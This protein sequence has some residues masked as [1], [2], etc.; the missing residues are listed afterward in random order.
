MISEVV[1]HIGMHK[2]GTTA[3]QSCLKN[4]DDGSIRMARLPDINHSVPIYSLFSESRNDYFVH[5]KKGLNANQIKEYNQKSKIRLKNEL[6]L[7]RDKLIIS[8]ED[9]SLLTK[10]EV[11]A[12]ISFLKERASKVRVIAYVRDPV[13]FASSALQQYIQGGMRTAHLPTPEYRNRFSAFIESTADSTEFASFQKSSL[14]KNCVLKD[15]CNRIDLDSS[16]LKY[17]TKNE[18]ISLECAQLL[19]H[20]NQHGLPTS[21][22]SSLHT[23]RK[24]FIA[25]LASSINTSKLEIPSNLIWTTE[26]VA[27]S[28]WMQSVSDIQLIPK[29]IECSDAIDTDSANKALH[30][31]LNTIKY[32]TLVRL[33]AIVTA[34][35]NEVG[36]ECKVTNL[37]NFL[38]SQHY[39]NHRH[40]KRHIKSN[41]IVKLFNKAKDLQLP[42]L[43]GKIEDAASQGR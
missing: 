14:Y 43:K 6:A 26:N 5:Q 18:S 32:S 20:F 10:D 31:L 39:F 40:K 21:G 29:G 22:N 41:K 13:G 11:L 9:I 30:E 19:Y 28:L 8:G 42:Q 2:T 16:H 33:K 12:L 27:D 15:F 17:S 23:C 1:L 38:F 4:Y 3:I 24:S 35:D 25:E 36:K 37:L 7:N 34:I